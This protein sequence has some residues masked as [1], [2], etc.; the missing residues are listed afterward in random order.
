MWSIKL[1]PDHKPSLMQLNTYPFSTF[2]SLPISL[3][4]CTNHIAFNI[5]SI[6]I[7]TTSAFS[8][9]F[10]LTEDGSLWNQV[11]YNK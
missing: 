5:K 11:A 1:L 4:V 8:V 9:I 7:L 10:L 6:N 3:S 2:T